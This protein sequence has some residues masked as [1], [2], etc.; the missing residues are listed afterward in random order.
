MYTSPAWMHRAAIESICG[1]CVRAGSVRL[2]PQL[3]T[4]WARIALTLRRDGRKHDF[5]I[6]AAVAAEEIAR[7]LASGARSLREGEWLVLAEAGDASSHLVI[8]SAAAQRP[9]AVQRADAPAA[10]AG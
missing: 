7:A 5:V 9:I 3:P 4:H 10:T 1:L 6:C 8:A 2:T